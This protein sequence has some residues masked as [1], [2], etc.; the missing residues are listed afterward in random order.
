LRSHAP[1]A[2]K[3][4]APGVPDLERR[5]WLVSYHCVRCGER[6][7]A[8]EDGSGAIKPSPALVAQFQK[9]AADRDTEYAHGQG[10]KARWL[11]RGR[12]PAENSPVQT[13]I[14]DVRCY[15]GPIPATLG[16]LPKLKPEHHPAMIAPFGLPDELEPGALCIRDCE[17]RGVHLTLLRPDGRGKAG[18]GRDKLMVGRSIG[19]PIV[20]APTNDLLGLAIT[21][22]I[23]DAL[24][25]H[26]AT[27]LGVWAAGSASRIPAL[28]NV[29]PTYCES[30]TVAADGDADG[31]SAA[32][33]FL[34]AFNR[35][36]VRAVAVLPSGRAA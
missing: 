28:A 19:W 31:Q 15:Q 5:V 13:Y 33:A 4:Q 12:Q 14:R 16:F 17:V 22:G 35:R 24:S 3:S 29:V 20:V 10:K 34:R 26:E 25:V 30:V 9:E 1:L 11:Y 18:T 36:D 8:V 7:W 2:T 6:G 23:E 27:G 32:S 21:E